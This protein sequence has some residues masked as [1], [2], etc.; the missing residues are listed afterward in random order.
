MLLIKG[1]EK[2]PFWLEKIGFGR[3]LARARLGCSFSRA[4][5]T[6]KSLIGVSCW[7]SIC[8]SS[9]SSL[10]SNRVSGRNRFRVCRRRGDRAGTERV[11]ASVAFW[12]TNFTGCMGGCCDGRGLS[13]CCCGFGGWCCS[14]WG[15]CGG[16]GWVWGAVGSGRFKIGRCC[17]L[18]GAG[19]MFCCCCCWW[20]GG[21]CCAEGGAGSGDP[22]RRSPL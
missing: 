14:S 3:L 4:D 10:S 16:C 2:L 9:I 6:S 19:C 12:G 7:N 1:N 13:C 22:V 11:S 8:S 21:G 15:V 5:N 20:C 17:G 18:I